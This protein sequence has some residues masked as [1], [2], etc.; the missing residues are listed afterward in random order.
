MNVVEFLVQRRA[1]VDHAN[2]NGN[3]SLHFAMSYD[4]SGKMGEF[5][6]NSGADDTIENKQGFTPCEHGC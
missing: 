1:K 6:I 4:R 2:A 5:L 3:T